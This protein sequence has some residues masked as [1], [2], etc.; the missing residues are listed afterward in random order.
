MKNDSQNKV[1]GRMKPLIHRLIVIRTLFKAYHWVW[2]CSGLFIKVVSCMVIGKRKND[3][4]IF[5][6][7]ADALLQTWNICN[8]LLDWSC[9]ICMFA[10]KQLIS[11]MSWKAQWTNSRSLILDIVTGKLLQNN[12]RNNIYNFSYFG[13]KVQYT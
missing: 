12:F 9:H 11:S 7:I 5:V 6:F 10:A 3:Q 8:A 13:K 2:C 4:S 1:L